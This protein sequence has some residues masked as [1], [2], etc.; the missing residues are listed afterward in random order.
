MIPM[1]NRLLDIFDL[2][3]QNALRVVLIQ[4]KLYKI[5]M[6]LFIQLY[7]KI[8]PIAKDEKAA[9]ELADVLSDA[10]HGE[11]VTIQNQKTHQLRWVSLHSPP[12]HS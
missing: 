5:G 12:S 3:N 7:E 6:S 9:R 2:S 10:V 11:D 8:A 1:D 4:Q